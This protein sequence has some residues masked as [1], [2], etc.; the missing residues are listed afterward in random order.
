MP[1]FKQYKRKGLSEMRP[2]K[3]GED[4]SKISIAEVD[5]PE[6]DMGNGCT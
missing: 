2:Y 3:K 4:C 6:T 5:D 1:E